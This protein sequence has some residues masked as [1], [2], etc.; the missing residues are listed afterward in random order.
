VERAKAL[1]NSRSGS[2]AIRAPGVVQSFHET[3]LG[4]SRQQ[5]SMTVGPRGATPACQRS[6]LAGAE[7]SARTCP[8]SRGF[9]SFTATSACAMTPRIRPSES[10]TGMRRS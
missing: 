2:D 10:V 7:M 4:L 3:Q 8:T 1:K 6:G 5:H 9:S